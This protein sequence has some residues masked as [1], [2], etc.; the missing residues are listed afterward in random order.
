MKRGLHYNIH[1]NSGGKYL[2]SWVY[3]GLDGIVT[4]FAV[5]AGVVGANLSSAI[6]LIMGF[7]NLIGDGISM[8]V[9]D[10]LSTK[11]QGEYYR[12]EKILEELQAKKNPSLEKEEMK[13]I[14]IKKGFKK[15]D[16]KK[17][18]L[19]I[20]KNKPYQAETMLHD[21]LG[22]VYD[23]I[24]PERNGLATFASFIIFGMIPL[25]IF[26]VSLIFNIQIKNA[27]FWACFLSG[28]S[29]FLLGVIKSKI[30]KKNWLKSGLVTLFVGGIAATAAYFVGE[31]L[32]NIV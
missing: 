18:S 9:G 26:V 29:M 5:V 8:A 32:S 12:N 13:N 23:N 7:A 14:L 6:I 25:V 20:S 21:E 24:H 2:K 31:L 1:S 30:T 16:A 17:I 28:I 22:L 11:S 27:F 15:S 19:L 3:G 4:T 10:Y